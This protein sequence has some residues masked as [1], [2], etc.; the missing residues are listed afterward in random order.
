M[1]NPKNKAFLAWVWVVL[2]SIGIFLTVPVGRK[3]QRYVYEHWGR[4][5]F[6]YSV[7]LAIGIGFISLSY[8]LIFKLR[9]R[10]PSHYVWLFII[11][12]LYIY[13]T[14]KLWK[15]PE[16]AVHFLEY[17][18]LSFFL[19]K[20][21]SIS[22]KDRSIYFTATLF[23][24]LIGTFDEIFQWITPERF[25]DFR[26]AGLNALSG[27][28]F[29]LAVWKIVKPKIISQKMNARSFRILTSVVAVCLIVLGFCVSNTPER[30]GRYTSFLPGLSFLQKQESMSEF[31]YKHQ[32]PEIGIFYSRLSKKRLHD[33]DSQKTEEHA[34]ILNNTVT[35]PYEEFLGKY[36]PMTNPFLH[37]LRVHVFRRDRYFQEGRTAAKLDKKQESYF[38]A[39]KENLILQKYF[40]LTTEISAYLWDKDK[41]KESEELIDKSRP[42][43]SPVS[44]GLFTAFSENTVWTWIF[45]SL[46]LMGAV[47]IFLFVKKKNLGTEKIQNKKQNRPH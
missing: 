45:I 38:V 4:E 12:G 23:A 8:I 15:I 6:G 9:I 21:L 17:G 34:N 42:Y 35:M 16:E 18:L 30:V 37:E 32:D 31:G 7:L 11:S 28:L 22:V 36:S 43:E 33:L 26:D 3:I 29:Q 47:N 25:W 24:L 2:C 1:N 44:A 13:F 5:L 41:I 46:V 39:Y 10:S 19:F 27:G 20:A 40:T 14:L